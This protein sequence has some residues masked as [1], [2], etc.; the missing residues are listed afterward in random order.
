MSS[1]A[2]SQTRE[3]HS[4]VNAG[5]SDRGNGQ[6]STATTNIDDAIEAYGTQ[7]SVAV[8]KQRSGHHRQLRQGSVSNARKL[9]GEKRKPDV[10]T[11][12]VCSCLVAHI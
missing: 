11:E 2:V 6:P 4:Y 3:R 9:H 8:A 10:V 1:E 12:C 7:V 5:T